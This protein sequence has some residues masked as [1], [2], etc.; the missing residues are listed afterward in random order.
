MGKDGV[1]GHRD[2]GKT[3]GIVGLGH[4]G[5]LVVKRLSGFEPTFLG[6]D[7]GTTVRQAAE[8]GVKLVSLDELFAKS[9]YV[10]LHLPETAETR[11]WSIGP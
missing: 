8:L 6:F 7:P 11:A 2:H 10:T 4:I 9:D 5:L 3:I 1:H